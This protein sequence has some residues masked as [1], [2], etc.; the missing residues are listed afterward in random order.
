MKLVLES[1]RMRKFISQLVIARANK[2][3][4]EKMPL[5]MTVEGVMAKDMSLNVVGMAGVWSKSFFLEYDPK[6]ANTFVVAASLLDGLKKGFNDKQ[7]SLTIEDGSVW[8][9]GS[10]EKYDE[11]LS[12][13][14]PPAK[15]VQI[16]ND[17]KKGLI[18]TKM[19]PTVA[20]LIDAESLS[21][22]DSENYALK[23][24]GDA[25]EIVCNPKDTKGNYTK[26]VPI[27]LKE[28]IEDLNVSYA[29]N[30]FQSIASNLEGEVWLHLDKNVMV[31][32]KKSKD[33]SLTYILT[34][35]GVSES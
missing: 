2:A 15:F 25:I 12:T 34:G 27:K 19:T 28:K 8:I 1:D 31:L 5:A 35:A 18:P 22:P 23:C 20:V 24:A 13:G 4:L 9:K 17:P 21:M 6:D 11:E 32:S 16:T 10:S 30:F 26:S 7:L 33:H 14:E 29:G 3:L